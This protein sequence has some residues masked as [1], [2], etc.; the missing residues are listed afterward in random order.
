MGVE[1]E[2]CEG[3][4]APYNLQATRKTSMYIH[5]HMY[6]RTLS[7]LAAYP[8]VSRSRFVC[9]PV[10][11]GLAFSS[12]LRTLPRPGAV[13]TSAWFCFGGVLAV[14]AAVQ[15]TTTT[16]KHRGNN[17]NAKNARRM[18]TDLPPS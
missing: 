18:T 16:N 6:V 14:W 8:S 13:G 4:D 7:R 3:R 15:L 2:R 12:T 5:T 10:S 17:R 11:S 9:E 1:R